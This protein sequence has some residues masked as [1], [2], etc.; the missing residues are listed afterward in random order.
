MFM[1]CVMVEQFKFRFLTFL[2]TFIS[3]L[4]MELLLHRG[5]AVL[6]AASQLVGRSCQLVI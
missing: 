5:A 1:F 2:F 4:F 3:A 6:L